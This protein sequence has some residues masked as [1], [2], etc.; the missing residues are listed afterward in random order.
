MAE[1]VEAAEAAPVEQ[2]EATTPAP[3][4]PAQET[5]DAGAAPD[6]AQTTTNAAA[7]E[8]NT[9][10]T[11]DV[12]FAIDPPEGV[13]EDM[14][15]EFAKFN[16]TAREWLKENPDMTPKE[17]LERSLGY[18]AELTQKQMVEAVTAHNERV[19]GWLNEAKADKE[20]GGDQFDKVAASVVKTVKEIGGEDLANHLDH[21][22]LANHPGFIRLMAR[23]ARAFE[24]SPVLGPGG[25]GARR[26]FTENLYGTNS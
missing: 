21:T 22:G 8:T 12:E 10:T 13:G 5:L 17:L 24:Q 11:A 2:A 25:A 4:A 14:K 20:I 16:E 18:Q 9:E 6:G 3:E 7:E 1:Q 26:N 23:A 19:E 15:A